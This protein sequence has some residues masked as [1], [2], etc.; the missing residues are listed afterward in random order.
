MELLFLI[1]TVLYVCSIISHY[2]KD[3][4]IAYYEKKLENRGIDDTVKNISL[5]EIIKS[6]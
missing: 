6:N 2:K 3:F 1:S 5:I 4:K